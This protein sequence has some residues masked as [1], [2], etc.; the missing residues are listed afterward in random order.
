MLKDKIDEVTSILRNAA[1]FHSLID[2]VLMFEVAYIAFSLINFFP[3]LLASFISSL[4]LIFKWSSGL[5]RFTELYFEKRFPD[6]RYKLTTA[7]E[8]HDKNSFV[9]ERLRRE[10]SEKLK[11]IDAGYLFN[12]RKVFAQSSIIVIL[13]FSIIFIGMTDTQFFDL[14][15]NIDLPENP[16]TGKATQQNEQ[17]GLDFKSPQKKD[18]S[19]IEDTKD[20]DFRE[21]EFDHDL[22]TVG[23]K[24]YKDP[25]TEEEQK[26]VKEYFENI[27]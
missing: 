19:E 3:V 13:C 10:V 6:L 12:F 24:E 8:C 23:A 27:R 11:H 26:V 21:D 1:F 17:D 15:D 22:R 4:Y 5:S 25:M 2:A 18:L 16:I 7:K 14:E 20:I 9:V